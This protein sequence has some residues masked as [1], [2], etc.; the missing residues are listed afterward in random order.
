MNYV[1][2]VQKPG[3]KQVSQ[4]ISTSNKNNGE[5][6]TISY[7]LEQEPKYKNTNTLP[8]SSAQNTI[9]FKGVVVAKDK[10]KIPFAKIRMI[11]M[12]NGKIKELE[13]DING[14]FEQ[15]LFINKTYKIYINK[16]DYKLEDD[17]TTFAMEEGSEM[18]RDFV[19]KQTADVFAL[20]DKNNPKLN[21]P[22]VVSNPIANKPPKQEPT[23]TVEPPK[24]IQEPVK[25]II[26]TQ[27]PLQQPVVI[28]QE[29]IAIV[30]QPV[31]TTQEPVG[32]SQPPILKVEPTTQPIVNEP[33][34]VIEQK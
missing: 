1:I 26:T 28:N 29:P 4:K 30:S 8:P 23:P 5:T 7:D 17:I 12:D 6:I 19:F 33:V 2:V 24:Q 21:N 16:G 18:F 20:L 31:I 34:A 11:N 10:G 25:P 32:V 14:K 27:Q 9:V 15:L 3:Y 22:Q 13:S